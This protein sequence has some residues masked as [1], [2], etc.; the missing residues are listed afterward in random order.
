MIKTKKKIFFFGKFY[1]LYLS[2]KT[3]KSI[4]LSHQILLESKRNLLRTHHF[5][6]ILQKYNFFSCLQLILKKKKS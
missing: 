6:Y 2:K 4:F 5:P 3:K 1:F